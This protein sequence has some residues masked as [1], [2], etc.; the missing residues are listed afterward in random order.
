MS[1]LY[2]GAVLSAMGGKRKGRALFA[3]DRWKNA[4]AVLQIICRFYVRIC[5][6]FLCGGG[7][8]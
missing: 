4:D 6:Y 8:K 1:I 5:A 7:C 2:T 3:L